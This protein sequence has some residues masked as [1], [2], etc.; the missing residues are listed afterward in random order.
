[1][2]FNFNQSW[3]LLLDHHIK[4]SIGDYI[5]I[6]YFEDVLLTDKVFIGYMEGS[7]NVGATVAGISTKG[8]KLF[9][10][11]SIP[12]LKILNVKDLGL[13]SFGIEP[14]IQF[15]KLSLETSLYFTTILKS[16]NKYLS[17]GD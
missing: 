4:V 1:M 6:P 17:N 12:E 7:I 13:S 8:I 14:I 9:V 10:T 11:E 15:Q 5:T 16:P 2:V 3:L